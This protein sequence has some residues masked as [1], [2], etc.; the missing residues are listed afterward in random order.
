M[1]PSFS[2]TPSSARTM[3]ISRQSDSSPHTHDDDILNSRTETPGLTPKGATKHHHGPDVL[4]T[5]PSSIAD[6]ALPPFLALRRLMTLQCP[7]S[8][9]TQALP[10]ASWCLLAQP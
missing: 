3:P 5:P 2:R 6:V 8:R 7:D 10:S 9:F 4:L 1:T